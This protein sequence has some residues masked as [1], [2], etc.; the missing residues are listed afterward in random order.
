MLSNSH[1]P[2]L[3]GAFKTL[4]ESLQ[5]TASR[6]TRSCRAGS[7]RIASLTF[8][9][10]SRRPRRSRAT[11]FRPVGS[12]PRRRSRLRPHSCAR[13]ARA[14]SPGCISRRRRAHE[15]DMSTSPAPALPGVTFEV[16]RFEWVADDRLEVVGRW[17]GLRGHRFL[18]PTLDV[19]AG[20]ARRGCSRSSST[21]PGRPRRARSGWRPSRGPAGARSSTTPS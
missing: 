12:G 1:R 9:G 10:R 8:T 16:E 7:R 3:L 14:T 2:G 5:A 21:S 17:F 18:R 4:A 11:R 13:S 6:S 19:Q 20:G 15:L